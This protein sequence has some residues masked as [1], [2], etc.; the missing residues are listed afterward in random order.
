MQKLPLKG[1]Q[2]TPSTDNSK[3]VWY[4]CLYQKDEIEI[5]QLMENNDAPKKGCNEFS[6]R[7]LK[8]I[9]SSSEYTRML[10]ISI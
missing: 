4:Y 7:M 10:R 2:S 6:V 8:Y 5:S 9:P 3:E 1:K